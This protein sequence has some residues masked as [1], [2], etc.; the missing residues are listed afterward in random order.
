MQN[1]L[2]EDLEVI[3]AQTETCWE[4]LRGQRLFLTGGTGFFGCWLLE[5]F[6]WA[7]ERLALDAEVVVLTRNPE[8]FRRKA[9]HLADHRAVTLRA[10]DVRSFEYPPGEFARVIHAA[11]DTRAGQ[12][13]ND[14]LAALDTIVQGTR[15]TLEFARRC[16]ARDFL[17]T[18]SGAVYGP[19]PPDLALMPEDY[20]GGPDPTAPASLYAEGKRLA[21]L[22]CVL[23][24]D[25]YEVRAK[26]ARCF[27]FVGPY[28]PLDAHFAIGNFIGDG[29]A[30]GPIRV[31]GDGT[32]YRS[33]LYAADLAVWL[34]TILDRG[35]PSR[36]YNVGA[37]E[38]INIADLAR[39][40][41]AR[42]SPAPDVEIARTPSPGTTA[43][44]YVPSTARARQELGLCLVTP[45]ESAIDKTI[46]YYRVIRDGRR[47]SWQYEY[48]T[49]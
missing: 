28:L 37:E 41:A 3:L 12:A 27:A 6:L 45:L 44:R 38:A 30:G 31:R 24:N 48:R 39:L 47:D 10:G 8:A 29:L 5:S 11:N 18:S 32:P 33:Y 13:R 16:G 17:F 26:I 43:S 20:V 40:V 46:A 15:H 34:W 9:P 21:E 23:Y 7:N 22:L 1:P 49:T 36:P 19:Q 2:A 14:C 35:E 42:F 25:Q 4:G